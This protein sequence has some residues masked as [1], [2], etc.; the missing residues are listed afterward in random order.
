MA[1]IA[2]ADKKPANKGGQK[3]GLFFIDV[4]PRL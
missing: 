4:L 1:P 3:N 2:G